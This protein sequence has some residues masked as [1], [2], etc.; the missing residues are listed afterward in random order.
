VPASHALTDV[1][2]AVSFLEFLAQ[3]ERCEALDLL[4]QLLW[5]MLGIGLVAL[6]ANWVLGSGLAY[7]ILLMLHQVQC[8]LLHSSFCHRVILIMWTDNVQVV[9]QLHM[10]CVVLI[11]KPGHMKSGRK[12]VVIEKPG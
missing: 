11:P 9:I 7:Y 5:A 8:V 12:Q 1:V 2:V 4:S 3:D 6:P 10:Y